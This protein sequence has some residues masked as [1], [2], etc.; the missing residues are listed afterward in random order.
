[1]TIDE[2]VLLA[3]IDGELDRETAAAVAAAVA[4]DPALAAQAEA[5]RALT[6]RF[7]AGFAPIL[8]E[9]VPEA[10]KAAAI[11]RVTEVIDFSARRAERQALPP[12][13]Y[14]RPMQWLALAA[15]LVIG[16]V[17]GRGVDVAGQP[18][19][20]A[21]KGGVLVASGPLASALDVQL[22]S[23]PGDDPAR[24]ML[25]FK[26]QDGR[27]C[28]SWALAG[29]KGVACRTGDDWRIAATVAAA[30]EGDYR[31]AGAD[32]ALMASVDSMIAGEPLDAEQERAAKGRGW[33]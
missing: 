31:M 29:Q 18:P 27:Y 28:R 10:I 30:P 22:A 2:G 17:I 6:A 19:A 3:W 26:S 15:T 1:M 7:G 5:H 33:Q 8:N 23:A 14:R 25:S 20:I 24:I 12:P 32:P 21:E 16:V 11:P 4:A 9:P 13:P